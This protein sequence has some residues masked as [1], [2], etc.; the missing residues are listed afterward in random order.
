MLK[1]NIYA[2]ANQHKPADCLDSAFKEMSEPFADGHA[3]T[4]Q[5]G[6]RAT[7]YTPHLSPPTL[8][9]HP[10]KGRPL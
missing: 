8:Q 9:R 2:Q 3:N 1:Q 10:S 4:R 7:P 6:G 5:S